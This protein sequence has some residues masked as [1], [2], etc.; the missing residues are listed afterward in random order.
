MTYR[1]LLA[2]TTLVYSLTPSLAQFWTCDA[3]EIDAKAGVSAIAAVVAVALVMH[4]RYRT[5]A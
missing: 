5:A 1:I 4:S 3:P 2:A